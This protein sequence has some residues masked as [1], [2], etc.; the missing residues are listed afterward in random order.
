MNIYRIVCATIAALII[1]TPAFAATTN[2]A[3]TSN[4]NPATK[5]AMAN[6]ANKGTGGI[7][8]ADNESATTTTP[9]AT[10][11]NPVTAKININKATVKELAA[12]KG[13][14]PFKARAIVAYRKKNGN[15]TS[16]DD[17]S[18]VKG[19]KRMKPDVLKEVQSQLSL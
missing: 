5:A 1:A 9:A 4:S 19:F 18:K 15:F 7:L 2:A 14:N 10:A 8:I 3:T 6:T 16:L 17:L 11:A 12:L 13:V